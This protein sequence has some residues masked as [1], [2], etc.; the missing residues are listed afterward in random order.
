MGGAGAADG[1]FN[2]WFDVPVK[3]IDMSFNKPFMYVIRDKDTGEVWFTG[4]VYEPTK[5]EYQELDW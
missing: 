4:T 1:G 5:F 3:I 2:Y